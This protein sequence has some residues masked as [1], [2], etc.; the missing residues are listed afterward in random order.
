MI[1]K[2]VTVP[3]KRKVKKAVTAPSAVIVLEFSRSEFRTIFI[4]L[5]VEQSHNCSVLIA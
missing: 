2:A 1:T 5:S 3:I 4:G